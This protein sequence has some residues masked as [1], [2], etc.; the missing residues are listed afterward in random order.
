MIPAHFITNSRRAM[1]SLGSKINDLCNKH[2][3]TLPKKGKPAANQWT[4]LSAVVMELSGNL[5]V[6][7]MATGT[8]CVGEE[9][10]TPHIVSDSHAEV[11][12]LRLFRLFLVEDITTCLKS[13]GGLCLQKGV[14][15][16]FVVKEGVTLHFYS[17]C[18]MCGDATISESDPK[19][20]DKKESKSVTDNID[21][22]VST[23]KRPSAECN[24]SYS[25][26][27]KLDQLDQMS[28]TGAKCLL[29]DNFHTDTLKARSWRKTSVLRTKPGRGPVCL[30]LSCSDKL[31]KRQF[32][33]LQG[34]LLSKFLPAPIRFSSFCIGGDFSMSSVKRALLNRL[35]D[36]L[37]PPPQILK[38]EDAFVNSANNCKSAIGDVI[39][40]SGDV[41]AA[42]SSLL[43]MKHGEQ[44]LQWAGVKGK[45][46]GATKSSSQVKIMLPVCRAAML[47][48][49]T[50]LSSLLE[51]GGNV[52]V[53]DSKPLLEKDEFSRQ[54]LFFKC[55]S[56]YKNSKA[57]FCKYF[58]GWD[59]KVSGKIHRTSQNIEKEN[60]K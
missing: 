18:V 47:K 11:L 36:N 40:A 13:G 34:G 15:G 25:K 35:P 30:S 17:S 26:H 50:V 38:V 49:A 12:S 44:D 10:K 39:A 14:D 19:Q 46:Q 16:R 59:R 45:L 3:N 33:G 9:Q 20:T 8:K 22:C 29:S 43:W 51:S 28:R 5:T 42:S 4:V 56:S 27:P 32:L 52:S 60:G 6:L 2:Y 48:Q 1:D 54:Y 41:I 37:L 23:R 55:E 57:E 53:Q 58:V 31:M 7:T 21:D 24:S